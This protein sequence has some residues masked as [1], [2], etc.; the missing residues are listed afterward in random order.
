MPAIDGLQANAIAAALAQAGGKWTPYYRQAVDANGVPEGE[1]M[2]IGCLLG[3]TYSKGLASALRVD[4]PGVIATK[5][6]TR[7]EG[8]LARSC[9]MPKMGDALGI[10]GKRIGI[11]TVN[12]DAYPLLLLTLDSID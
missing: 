6:V 4:I 8:L 7:F 3:K 11:L 2:R 12:A 5:D 1:P 9:S 10:D